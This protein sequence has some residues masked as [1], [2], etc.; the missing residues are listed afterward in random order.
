MKNDGDKGG[1]ARGMR[2]PGFR[3]VAVNRLDA[4]EPG[5]I[6]MNDRIE[7]ERS[8]L[9]LTVAQSPIGGSI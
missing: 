9:L 3:L 5:R 8:K 6:V 7:M 4:D 2:D 1:A